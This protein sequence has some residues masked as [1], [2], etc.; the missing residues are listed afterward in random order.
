MMRLKSVSAIFLALCCLIVMPP[1]LAEEEPAPASETV[2][3]TLIN[4]AGEASMMQARNG[5]GIPALTMTVNPDGGEDYSVTLQIL[6]LM[7]AM[8]FCPL[9]LSS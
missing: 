8:A 1:A 6:A 9:S 5:G 2:T 7:T 3:E 4:N